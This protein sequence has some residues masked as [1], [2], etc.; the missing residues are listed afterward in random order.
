MEHP[1]D[2]E[3]VRLTEGRYGFKI[4]DSTTVGSHDLCN[5]MS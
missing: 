3:A 2:H 5:R 1:A 4:V